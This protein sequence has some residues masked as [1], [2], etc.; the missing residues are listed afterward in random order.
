MLVRIAVDL[1]CAEL[2]ME[3]MINAC[4]LFLREYP[5]SYLGLFGDVD[6]NDKN[7]PSDIFSRIKI[8]TS[9]IIVPPTISAME[10]LRNYR[11]SSMGL[12][13]KSVKND[14]YSVAISCGNTGALIVLA[15]IIIGRISGISRPALMAVLP[16]KQDTKVYMMDIGANHEVSASD[17]SNFA[18]M[19]SI[20]L[21]HNGIS[22]PIV[23]LLNI[24]S[25]D[26]KGTQ[27][28]Q[29]AH[30]L[31]HHNTAI[32]YNGFIEPHHLFDN[33]C[34]LVIC[35]GFSGNLVIKTM[36][37]TV[38]LILH[39]L[40]NHRQSRYM[41][42]LYMYGMRN[43]LRRKLFKIH[44]DENSGALLLGLK[45]TVVKS[46]GGSSFKGF[47]NALRKAYLMSKTN[48]ALN[49]RDALEKQ[50]SIIEKTT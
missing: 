50:N 45:N 16:T 19:G 40:K 32:N 37:G 13:L 25:E 3:D 33:A 15:T 24:G 8:H 14:Q 47:Y 30:Y 11:N 4:F 1:G 49:V 34:N 22:K 12:A 41:E 21:Q 18:V 7:I 10:A 26:Q 27:L 20:A 39:E 31:L 23:A 29:K 2:S 5:D 38:H 6:F 28:I 9:N 42:K 46:H 43:I 35:D 44:P 36:E 48:L 17:L